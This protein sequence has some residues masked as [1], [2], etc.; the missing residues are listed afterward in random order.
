MNDKV[1]MDDGKDEA[2]RRLEASERELSD[3]QSV[4]MQIL[5]ESVQQKT[6]DSTSDYVVGPKDPLASGSGQSSQPA[7]PVPN[8]PNVSSPFSAADAFAATT[9]GSVVSHAASAAPA[10]FGHGTESAGTALN[11]AGQ[12]ALQA[13]RDQALATEDSDVDVIVKEALPP[14]EFQQL[15]AALDN[16]ELF[17]DDALSPQDMFN[18][19]MD[20]ETPM[21]AD[22]L[23]QTIDS[24]SARLE[25]LQDVFDPIFG[26]LGL[27]VQNAQSELSS[28]TTQDLTVG[29]VEDSASLTESLGSIGAFDVLDSVEESLQTDSLIDDIEGIVDSITD[30][31]GSG[32]GGLNVPDAVADAIDPIVDGVTDVVDG[33]TDVVDGV[34]DGVTDVV[35][36]VT[37]G[38]TDVVDGVTGGATDPVTDVVDGVIG[39]LG[40]GGETLVE[41]VDGLVDE[42]LGLLSGQTS[43]PDSSDS[44]LMDLGDLSGISTDAGNNNLNL[45]DPTGGLGS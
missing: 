15:M 27:D 3:P 14:N 5:N 32:S 25:N 18:A 26:D 2:E 16:P 7:A 19:L 35:D 33:V 9:A 39:L 42:G 31:I 21:T 38:I 34:V 12:A 17:L 29:L 40:D 22:Q 45:D 6:G 20:A 24:L 28:A 13:A 43:L 37:G 11:K 1:D 44:D 8:S 23:Q 10:Q 30:S 41:G 4:N 36:G